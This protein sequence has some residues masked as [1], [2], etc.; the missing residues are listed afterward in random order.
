MWYPTYDTD[1]LSPL[2][3]TG[4]VWVN[5]TPTP[6]L[7][8]PLLVFSHGTTVF[9]D[10]AHPLMEHM[11]SHGFVAIA[12]NHTGDT[13]LNLGEPRQTEMFFMRPQDIS[14]TLDWAYDLEGSNPLSDQLT[15]DVVMTGHSF[16]GFTGFAVAGAAYSEETIAQ[17][18]IPEPSGLCS[19]MTDEYRALF[20]G[21]FKDPRIDLLIPMAPGNADILGPEGVSQIDIPVLH[22]SASGDQRTPNETNG[23]PYWESISSPDSIRVN[24]STGGHHSFVITC[25]IYPALGEGDGCGEGFI[26]W[27][28]ALEVVNTLVLSFTRYHFFGDNRA[29]TYLNGTADLPDS[30]TFSFK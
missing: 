10:V 1:G 26:H 25:Q 27:E 28:E 6:D 4:D 29:K 16:G 15:S 13:A 17:C 9:A 19:N 5:A 23:D 24:F 12:P 21:G 30:L 20:D 11:A 14:A 2:F 8:F 3:K 22:L 18:T 7:Q